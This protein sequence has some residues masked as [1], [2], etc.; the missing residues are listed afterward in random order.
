MKNHIAIINASILFILL[1][2]CMGPTTERMKPDD[3]A[4]AIE[5]EKQ[6]E[7]ALQ[8]SL[9]SHTR[10]TRVGWPILKAGLPFCKDRKTR[11]IIENITTFIFAIF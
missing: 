8:E 3:A 11:A 7:I 4:V 2:G 10:L 1:V 5:A 6:R 9:N